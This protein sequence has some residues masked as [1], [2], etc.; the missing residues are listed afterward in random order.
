MVSFCCCLSSK[1]IDKKLYLFLRDETNRKDS[2]YSKHSYGIELD[3]NQ[4]K[5]LKVVRNV[6]N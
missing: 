3:C 2:I 1:P 5:I 4:Y 6:V